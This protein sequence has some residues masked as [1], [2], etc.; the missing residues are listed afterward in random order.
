VD[1][2]RTYHDYFEALATAHPEIAHGTDG[3]SAFELI[4]VDE[5]FGAFR[6]SC[7]DGAIL[8][9]L[10]YS[11]DFSQEDS[12]L[13]NVNGAFLLLH[14]HSTRESGKAGFIDAMDK[15]DKISHTLI[16]KMLL[17]SRTGHPLFDYSLDSAKNIRVNQAI[18]AGDVNWS[19]F[20]V[21]FNFRPIWDICVTDDPFVTNGWTL[22]PGQTW[23]L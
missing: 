23:T 17:D 14:K 1:L 8:R 11:H 22:T 10:E 18:R 6:T 20:I 13:R 5:A 2:F 9:L 15:A 7:S 4:S 21:N 3:R 12:I 19:G 16:H